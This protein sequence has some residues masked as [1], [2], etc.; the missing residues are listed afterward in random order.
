[1]ESGDESQSNSQAAWKKLDFFFC[2][3]ILEG[4]VLTAGGGEGGG[5]EQIFK[6]TTFLLT[7]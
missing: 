2:L 6:E 1:M 4:R 5:G 3:T 7:A